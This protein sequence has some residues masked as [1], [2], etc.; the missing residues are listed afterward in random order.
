[1]PTRHTKEQYRIGAIGAG[2][3]GMAHIQH[4]AAC[5]R[6]ELCYVCDLSDERLKIAH[7]PAPNA[8]FIKD[9]ERMLADPSIGQRSAEL[10]LPV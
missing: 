2:S 9:F 6:W 4:I 10:R 7:Q 8:H 3:M 1:M 5:P